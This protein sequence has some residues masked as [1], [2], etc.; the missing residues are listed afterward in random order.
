MGINYV[1]TG[2]IY[3]TI[4]YN[5]ENDRITLKNSNYPDIILQRTYDEPNS[6]AWKWQHL[7]EFAKSQSEAK[8]DEYGL[9][10]EIEM[11]LKTSI[12][13]PINKQ[14]ET[15]R[16]ILKVYQNKLIDMYFFYKGI[17]N[18]NIEMVVNVSFDYKLISNNKI[19]NVYISIESEGYIMVTNKAVVDIEFDEYE[20]FWFTI[21]NLSVNTN[22]FPISSNSVV[23]DLDYF[24]RSV[25][26]DFADFLLKEHNIYMLTK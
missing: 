16:Q 8:I 6:L 19:T 20:E 21:T 11:S 17:N 12:L 18:P 25:L 1:N 14:V 2:T 5:S 13:S 23:L 7:Y 9:Y 26:Y 15:T 22:N 3:F 24:G 10:Y 4:T